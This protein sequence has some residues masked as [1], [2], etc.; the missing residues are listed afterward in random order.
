MLCSNCCGVDGD[1]DCVLLQGLSEAQSLVLA[2]DTETFIFRRDLKCCPIFSNLK[3]LSLDDYWCVPADFSALACFEH[4]P[5]LEK[6]TLKLFC[7]EPKSKVQMKGSPDPT[8]RSNAISEHLKLVE[9]KCEVV[10][11]GVL[12]VLE[13]LNKLGIR[14]YRFQF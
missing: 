4:C 5:V 8:E 11:D 3:T 14:S 6:L 7:K 10:D 1:T 13:F 9:V 12:T 2:S